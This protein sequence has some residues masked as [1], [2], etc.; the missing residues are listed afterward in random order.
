MLYSHNTVIVGGGFGGLYAAQSLAKSETNI[1]I[2]DKRN[3]HLFQPLLYQVA[4]GGLS[5]GDIS[6]P[7]RSILKK[8]DNVRVMMGEMVDIDPQNQQVIL[9]QGTLPYDSLILATGVKHH[10]F[11][12]KTWEVYAPGLKTVEDA[13]EIRRR[14]LLAFEE[15]EKTEDKEKQQQFL[16]FI[17]VG[18]G[19][20]GVELAGAL[21]DV[22]NYTLKNEFH[23]IDPTQAKI[24]LVEGTNRILPPYSPFLSQEAEKA[25]LRLG[26]IVLTD[27]MVT[28]IQ[29]G[30]VTMV[31]DGKEMVIPSRTVMW[32]AGVQASSIGEKLAEKTGVALDNAGRVKVEADLSVKN[33]ANIFVIGDL[34]NYSHGNNG[35]MLP[36][37]APVAMQ[38]GRYVAKQIMRGLKGKT[39][40]KFRYFDK[41][42]LA[43]IGRN[44][45]VA[46]LG[47]FQFKGLFAWLTWLFVHIAYLIEY[48][49]RIL[50]LT[51]W[52]VNYFTRKRGARLIAGQCDSLLELEEE[53]KKCL[54]CFEKD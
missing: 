20:T 52:A 36:G 2:V 23:S 34:A 54:T 32:A 30:H 28:D 4:T 17:I 5:P 1:T 3:F 47:K 50:V 44:A 15:A 38:E 45:A 39:R 18:G 40:T 33:Y 31:S 43:V 24:Y 41:G 37:V 42:S 51:Q 46:E 9:K 8:H 48:D 53:L 25:L 6:S 12:N 7:L 29:L 35:E 27:T 10:Y 19:P 49:N 26:V 14:I 21:A 16:N 22:A 13:L 11:G